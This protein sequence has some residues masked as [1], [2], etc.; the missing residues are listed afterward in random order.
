MYSYAPPFSRA[1][2]APYMAFID[3]VANLGW[4]GAA[5]LVRS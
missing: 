2:F 3:A 1:D 4:E 5:D